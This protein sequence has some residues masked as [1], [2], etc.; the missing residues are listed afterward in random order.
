MLVTAKPFNI[1]PLLA[2]GFFEE[3]Q[4]Q[5]MDGFSEARCHR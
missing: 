5:F 4:M 2:E 3:R 1:V